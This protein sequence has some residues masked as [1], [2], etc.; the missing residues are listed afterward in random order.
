MARERQEIVR[1]HAGEKR[2][3]RAADLLRRERRVRAPGAERP[4]KKQSVRL[5]LSYRLIYLIIEATVF[6]LHPL[7][8]LYPKEIDDLPPTG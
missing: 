1:H 3:E 5:A 6:Q 7:L 2:S 4:A 8:F